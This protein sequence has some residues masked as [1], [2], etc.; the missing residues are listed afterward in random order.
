MW[1]TLFGIIRIRCLDQMNC[2][3]SNAL[4]KAE[5]LVARWCVALWANIKVKPSTD[6]VHLDLIC[7]SSCDNQRE[8]INTM[9]L[10]KLAY[11]HHQYQRG[12]NGSIKCLWNRRIFGRLN[13]GSQ[14]SSYITVSN[15]HKKYGSISEQRNNSYF[16]PKIERNEN[17][18]AKIVCD[19]FWKVW[20]SRIW[21]L[22]NSGKS[23]LQFTIYVHHEL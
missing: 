17:Q 20:N 5:W 1:H 3:N 21:N 2:K 12:P 10:N 7:L 23:Q 13:V 18:K 15:G 6:K 16:C 22:G 4:I 8:V 11:M 19:Y 9:T 14:L